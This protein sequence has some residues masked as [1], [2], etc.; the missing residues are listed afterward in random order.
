MFPYHENA[1]TRLG[2]KTEDQNQKISSLLKSAEHRTVVQDFCG[3]ANFMS[4]LEKKEGVAYIVNDRLPDLVNLHIQIRDHPEKIIEPL[5]FVFNNLLAI[6]DL[7]EREKHLYLLYDHCLENL[8]RFHVWEEYRKICNLG[9]QYRKVFIE[10]NK[11]DLDIPAKVDKDGFIDYSGGHEEAFPKR[12]DLIFINTQDASQNMSVADIQMPE[13]KKDE[14]C[15]KILRAVDYDKTQKWEAAIEFLFLNMPAF[16]GVVSKYGY[17]GENI[18]DADVAEYLERLHG[19]YAFSEGLQGVIITNMD[20]RDVIAAYDTPETVFS[21]DVPY[22]FHC[23]TY[24]VDWDYTDESDL[25]MLLKE[26]KGKFLLNGRSYFDDFFKKYH[27]AFRKDE[28]DQYADLVRENAYCLTR[29]A[30]HPEFHILAY[31]FRDTEEFIISNYPM[32]GE[33]EDKIEYVNGVIAKS[34]QLLIDSETKIK[35]RCTRREKYGI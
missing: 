28:R 4:N 32:L 30:I 14:Y 1:I 17:S 5:N 34:N 16:N 13:E 23:N 20:F 8:R 27:Q 9:S 18:T 31:P 22:I 26:L 7:K 12:M 10:A 25:F 3:T 29:W 15:G 21:M 11:N 33:Q 19:M 2:H 24:G 6:E 35:Q